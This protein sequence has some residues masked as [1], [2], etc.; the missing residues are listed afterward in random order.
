LKTE[1]ELLLKENFTANQGSPV[2]D[3]QNS[4]TIGNNGSVML[5]DVHLIEKL[6]HLTVNGYQN[7][8]YMPKV[9]AQEGILKYLKM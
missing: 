6:A 3:D 4:L 8:L 9:L 1:Q 7:G 2:S 5:Q